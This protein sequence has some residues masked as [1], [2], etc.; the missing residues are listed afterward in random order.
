MRGARAILTGLALAAVSA[1]SSAPAVPLDHLPALAGDYFPL[2][3]RSN[4]HLY[5]IYVRLPEGYSADQVRRYPIVYLLDG[6]SLFP[7]VGATT[8][9]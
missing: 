4:E 3:S 7:V 9:S 5:H 8:S 6:D 1:P 2:R